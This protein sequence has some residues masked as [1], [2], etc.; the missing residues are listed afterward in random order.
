MLGLREFLVN[1]R[2]N[3]QSGRDAAAT[4]CSCDGAHAV[5]SLAASVFLAKRAV[6]P[7]KQAKRGTPEHPPEAFG[8]AELREPAAMTRLRVR[9][10]IARGV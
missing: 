9:Q 1:Q 8:E 7:P 10:E 2:R 5:P 3:G 6:L 4:P